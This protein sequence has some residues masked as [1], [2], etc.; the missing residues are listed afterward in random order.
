[1][2]LPNNAM[3]P[4]FDRGAV[5]VGSWLAFDEEYEGKIHRTVSRL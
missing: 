2:N 3:V 1:M 4:N 5:K